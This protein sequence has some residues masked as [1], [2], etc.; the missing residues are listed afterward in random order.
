ML[1]VDINACG[2]KD[3]VVLPDVLS[4]NPEGLD[5][6]SN[7]LCNPWLAILLD[8]KGQV[9]SIRFQGREHLCG[10]A[11]GYEAICWDPEKWLRADLVD[12]EITVT[13]PGPIYGAVMSASIC[14]AMSSLYAIFISVYRI[15]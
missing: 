6:T 5:I 12:A 8:Q 14:Q 7:R 15:H 2:F 9:T 11:T 1:A 3:L 13:S 10:L 4:V